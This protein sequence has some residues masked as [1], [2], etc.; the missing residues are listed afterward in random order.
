KVHER[1]KKA[2]SHCVGFGEEV[3]CR[4]TWTSNT[5]ISDNSPA[6]VFVFKY[7]RLDIL[8]AMGI[9]PRTPRTP[10]E[11]KTQN[12]DDDVEI[13]DGPNGHDP[14]EDVKPRIQELEV[15]SRFGNI[16]PSLQ[17]ILFSQMELQR[18]RGQLPSS[19]DRKPSRVKLERRVSRRQHAA[20][21]VIDLTED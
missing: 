19:E 6:T 20:I 1:T 5:V 14:S 21:E 3:P 17:L 9:A 2:F 16:L 13:S 11:D 12:Y 15:N 8:Q 7:T 18:L 10:A 4:A